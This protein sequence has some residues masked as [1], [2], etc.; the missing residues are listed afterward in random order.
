[1]DTGVDKGFVSFLEMKFVAVH[2]SV[3]S[4]QGSSDET[5]MRRNQ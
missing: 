5:N 2:T 4:H 3:L 1:M